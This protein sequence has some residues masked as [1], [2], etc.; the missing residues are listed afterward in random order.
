MGIKRYTSTGATL[1]WKDMGESERAG[2]AFAE[3]KLQL[4]Y[5]KWATQ[6]SC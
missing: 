2:A 4:C 5:V 3:Q 1:L 6:E